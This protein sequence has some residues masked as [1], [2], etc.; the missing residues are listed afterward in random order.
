MA[1]VKYRVGNV[2]VTASG[3]VKETAKEISAFLDFYASDKQCMLCQSENLRP[4]HRDASGYDFYEI[5]CLDCGGRLQFGQRKDVEALFPK[6]KHDDGSWDN[7]T[8]GWKTKYQK[9]G[10]NGDSQESIPQEDIGD[11]APF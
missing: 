4:S 3:N 6:R 1:T 2:E 5:T 10:N 8:R 11:P 7:D 9:R